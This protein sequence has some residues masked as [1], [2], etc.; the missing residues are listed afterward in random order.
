MSEPLRQFLAKIALNSELYE[1]YVKDPGAAMK[2]AGLSDADQA[3]ITSGDA[4]ELARRIRNDGDADYDPTEPV[5]HA[6]YYDDVEVDEEFDDDDDPPVMH[7]RPAEGQFGAGWMPPGLAPL[8]PGA[9]SGAGPW[10]FPFFGFPV[11]HV[12]VW[13]APWPPRPRPEAGR[14]RAD[15]RAKHLQSHPPTRPVGNPVPRAHDA[16]YPATSRP[17]CRSQPDQHR[18]RR[19]PGR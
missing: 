8:S 12:V 7:Y 3:A 15:S 6:R 16:C 14:N 1:Q 13:H 19:L 2:Q 9:P 11:V 4:A 10:G 18:P 17:P 5:M